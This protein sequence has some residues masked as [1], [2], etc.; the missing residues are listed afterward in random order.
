VFAGELARCPAAERRELEAALCA[1]SGWT[2]WEVLRAEEGLSVELAGA[3]M[4]RTLR[5]LLA[6]PG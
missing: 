1:A 4:R 5:A 3:A 6:R 2:A